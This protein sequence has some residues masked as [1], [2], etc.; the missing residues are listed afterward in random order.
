LGLRV[1]GLGFR[2]EGI[3]EADV[4]LELLDRAVEDEVDL[5]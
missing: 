5:V 4:G 2:V 3:P 1:E